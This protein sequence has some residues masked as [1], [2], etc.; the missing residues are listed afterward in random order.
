ME[1]EKYLA[2][3]LLSAFNLG[4]PGSL[5]YRYASNDSGF[6]APV[7]RVLAMN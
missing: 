2:L 7:N 1:G 4:H 6:C 3:G 5:I